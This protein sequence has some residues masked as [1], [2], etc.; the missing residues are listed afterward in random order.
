MANDPKS[1]TPAMNFSGEQF[2]QLLEVLRDKAAGGGNPDLTNAI[3]R[4]A[5]EKART[6]RHSNAWDAGISPFSHPEGEMLHPKGKLDRETWFCSCKQE[7]S[8]LTPSE[9][10]LFNAI[11]VSK[12]W[13]GDPKFGADVTPKRR[14]IMLPH[15]SIDERM[16]LPTSLSLILME[17][18]SGEDA[19]DPLNMAEEMIE[20]RKKVAQLASIVQP[21]V[22]VGAP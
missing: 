17:L 7:E 5:D 22:P 16:Q 14:F 2:E 9:I 20:L 8:Q 6:T 18:I 1:T 12:T 11:Q 21:S 13:R 15:V 3:M 10:D 19:V 4:L